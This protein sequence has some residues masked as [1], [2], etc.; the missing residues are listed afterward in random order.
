M[1]NEIKKKILMAVGAVIL[2]AIVGTLVYAI[3]NQG[4][5]DNKAQNVPKSSVEPIKGTDEIVDPVMEGDK[6][7]P[8]AAPSDIKGTDEIIDPVMEEEEEK[9][10]ENKK[11]VAP[12]NIKG[13]DEIVDPIM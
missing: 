13:S 1:D 7:E 6:K 9:G 3:K 5:E 12:S 10:E 2:F 11:D 8:I 4:R